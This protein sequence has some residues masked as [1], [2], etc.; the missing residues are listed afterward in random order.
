[1]A[2]DFDPEKDRVN[3]DRHGISL[4]AAAGFDWDGVLVRPD[5]RRDYGEL[6]EIG[7]GMLGERLHCVVFTRRA[8]AHRIISLR[9]ANKREARSYAESQNYPP[10]AS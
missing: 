8:A 1:M 3:L 2:I 6:R 7:L 10:Y 9:K 5:L 4:A